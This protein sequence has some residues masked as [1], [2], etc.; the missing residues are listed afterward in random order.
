MEQT[1]GLAA[2]AGSAVA[3][4]VFLGFREKAL[5]G[6]GAASGMVHTGGEASISILGPSQWGIPLQT[7]LSCKHPFPRPGEGRRP[8]RQLQPGCALEAF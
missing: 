4:E 5:I 8:S 6:R 3:P 1:G 7:S 2:N